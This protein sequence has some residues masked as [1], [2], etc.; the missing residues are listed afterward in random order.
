MWWI[1]ATMV[2]LREMRAASAY[3]HLSEKHRPI[4][5]HAKRPLCSLDCSG[6]DM[7]LVLS[8]DAGFLALVAAHFRPGSFR[9]ADVPCR[10]GQG[11][12]RDNDEGGGKV[13]KF[14]MCMGADE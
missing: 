10:G 14:G 1:P 4:Q 13:V 2:L 9:E 7:R 6:T 8:C 3:L 12:Q 11:Y 5:H